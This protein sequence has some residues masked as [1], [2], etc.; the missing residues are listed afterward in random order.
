VVR[1]LSHV[2]RGGRGRKRERKK[3]QINKYS[4]Q[5]VKGSKGGG[6]SKC[7]DYIR[8]SL[9]GKGSP[10][11]GCKIQGRGCV[12]QPSPVTGRD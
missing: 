5:E 12:C 11:L 2:G 8:K 1:A 6:S 4:S 7:L 9:K 3:N 10:A